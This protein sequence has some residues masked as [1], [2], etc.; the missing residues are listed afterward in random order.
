MTDNKPDKPDEQ[1]RNDDRRKPPAKPYEGP[2]RRTGDR[3]DTN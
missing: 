2:E 1:R 3:R